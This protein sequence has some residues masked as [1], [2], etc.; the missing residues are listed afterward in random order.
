[1]FYYYYFIIIIVVVVPIIIYTSQVLMMLKII[2][3]IVHASDFIFCTFFFNNFKAF[4]ISC[5]LLFL[6]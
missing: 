6:I 3:T 1:M 5:F 4:P 2:F